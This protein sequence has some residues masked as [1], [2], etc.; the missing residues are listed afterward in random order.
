[1]SGGENDGGE[2]VVELE[3]SSDVKDEY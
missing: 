2:V 3:I 1:M